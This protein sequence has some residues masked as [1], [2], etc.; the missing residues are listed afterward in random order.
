MIFWNI[1]FWNLKLK[2]LK[3][4]ILE[5][6]TFIKYITQESK[7]SK[8]ENNSLN[9]KMKIFQHQN[10]VFNKHSEILDN[11]LKSQ[12]PSN[13]QNGLGFT[14]SCDSASTSGLKTIK[15]VKA[16]NV[17][18]EKV[19]VDEKSKTSFSLKTIEKPK[20]VK[21]FHSPKH[22]LGYGQKKNSKKI[23]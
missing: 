4:K 5:V 22:G 17:E 3:K 2:F 15:F 20:M 1:T 21:K 19:K 12:K 11:V 6:K 18:V 14:S 16:T 9:D 13:D 10:Q 7:D 8:L 23:F